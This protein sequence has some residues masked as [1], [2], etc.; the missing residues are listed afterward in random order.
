MVIWPGHR[1]HGSD[2]FHEAIFECHEDVD[3]GLVENLLNDLDEMIE[4]VIGEVSLARAAS[5]V[6]TDLDWR[7]ISHTL[8]F[9]N[10]RAAW[11]QR[12]QTRRSPTLGE[13]QAA[14]Y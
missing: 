12:L 9:G 2:P 8:I 3:V 13:T 11:S 10:P 14:I 6:I 7:S 5:Q 4:N 1:R